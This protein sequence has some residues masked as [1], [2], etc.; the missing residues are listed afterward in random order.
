MEQDDLSTYPI[1]QYPDPRLKRKAI[2]IDPKEIT[3]PKYQAV[4]EKMFRTYDEQKNCAALTA[5]QLDIEPAYKITVIGFDGQRLCLI[6]PEISDKEGTHTEEEGC[7]SIGA[8]L[9][10]PYEKVTR[11]AKIKVKAYNEKGEQTEFTAEGFLAKCIQHETDH[12]NG[13]I[14]IDH[15]TRLKRIKLDRKLKV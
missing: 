11:A 14:F 5:T 8:N 4:I 1:L 15:L 7:M 3:S 6:N 13:I 12:L 10:R 2:E 9:K